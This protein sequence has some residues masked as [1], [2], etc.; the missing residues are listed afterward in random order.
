MP[1]EDRRRFDVSALDR[2]NEPL[3][4]LLE[5]EAE[6][7]RGLLASGEKLREAIGGRV[8][9]AVGLFAR[10]GLA[11]LEVLE[12]AGWDIFTQRPRPSRARLARAAVVALV[13]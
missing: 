11:A 5:F 1:A 4:R 10:G 8:G 3:R 13:R 9:R 2:P 6:R 7:G 12:H